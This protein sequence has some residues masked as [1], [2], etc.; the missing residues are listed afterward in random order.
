MR[1]PATQ[2]LVDRGARDCARVVGGATVRPVQSQGQHP[3]RCVRAHRLRHRSPRRRRHA[4]RRGQECPGDRNAGHGSACREGAGRSAS[5]QPA[6]AGAGRA[7]ASW[8]LARSTC[9]RRR[10]RA[11]SACSPR[12]KSISPAEILLQR[13][14]SSSARRMWVSLQQRSGSRPPTIQP[15]CSASRRK[16][17]SPTATSRGSGTSARARWVRRKPWSGWPGSTAVD[18]EQA[19]APISFNRPSVA[20]IDGPTLTDC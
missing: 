10:R 18:A 2:R 3:R 13:G 16:A 17:S 4:D 11:P 20:A 8:P 12:E 1:G 19:A 7:A 6:V 14:T 5:R 15:S 9:R